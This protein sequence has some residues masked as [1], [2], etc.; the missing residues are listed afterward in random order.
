VVVD[1]VDQMVVMVDQMVDLADQEEEVLII[2]K[3][4]QG[5]RLTLVDN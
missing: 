3:H 1:S 4:P 5:R 2:E